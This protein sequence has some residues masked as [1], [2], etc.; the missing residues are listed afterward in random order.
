MTTVL[1]LQISVGKAIEILFIMFTPFR[2]FLLASR[3]IGL[4]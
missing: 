4:V 1:H 3:R 2:D